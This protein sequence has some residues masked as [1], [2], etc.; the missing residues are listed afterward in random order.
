MGANGRSRWSSKAS[1]NVRKRTVV[2]EVVRQALAEFR[3]K[4]LEERK[5][6][7]GLRKK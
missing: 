7:S 6:H 4:L 1:D 3:T 5:R 2:L